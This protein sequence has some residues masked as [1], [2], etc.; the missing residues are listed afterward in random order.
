MC[1]ALAERADTP[2][3]HLPAL[4]GLRGLA[5]L[6]VLLDHAS[7]TGMRF[8]EAMDLNRAGKY[9]V[10][11][12]FVLSAFLLTLPFCRPD[13]PKLD[14]ARTWLNYFLR[15]F[16]RIFPLYAIV[17]AVLG[18]LLP[19]DKAGSMSFVAHLLIRDGQDQFWSIPVEVKFYL[20]LPMIGVA[21][22]FLRRRAWWKALAAALGA[23][24]VTAA[25]FVNERAW[26]LTETILLAKSI[27]PFL[28]GSAAAFVHAT[29]VVRFARSRWFALG[30]EVGAFLALGAVVLRIPYFYER[31]F[32]VVVRKMPGD[33]LILGALWSVL[34]LG[35]LGGTGWMRSALAWPPLRYLGAISFSVYLWHR[36]FLSDVVDLPL[37][38]QVRLAVF[39]AIVVAV[40]SATYFLVERP[41]S[42]V[43]L[44]ARCE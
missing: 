17:L 33:Q 31:V 7:D 8:T 12:F 10:Y 21:L 37:P 34:I 9:G 41:L 13:G 25:V 23:V 2:P 36:K 29:V 3:E 15:R 40:A 20:V 26:S 43:R 4:D 16:V 27:R 32:G 30:C 18:V 44:R 28:F 22:A 14:D 6:L 38:A 39:I 24:A 11:L 19:A 1:A 42:R 35:A 5:V